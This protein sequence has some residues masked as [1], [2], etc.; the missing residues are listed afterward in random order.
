MTMDDKHK[1][2]WTARRFKE[3]TKQLLPEMFRTALGLTKDHSEAED[4]VH[5]AFVKAY[6]SLKN[7]G[8]NGTGSYRAWIT[9]ILINTYRDR[10]RRESR[11]PIVDQR[12][13]EIDSADTT[14]VIELSASTAPGPA[15]LLDQKRFASAAYAA[16]GELDSE[17]RVIVTLYFF[18]HQSYKQ[19]AEIVEVPIGTVMSRLSRGRRILRQKLA[20]HVELSPP[21]TKQS[22]DVSQSHSRLRQSKGSIKS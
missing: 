6:R 20:Q 16:I 11:S 21:S 13:V 8:F 17:V 2:G 18:D 3:Q 4:L 7:P 12:H 10:C 19:I 22:K 1:G 15:E 9:K 14:N 5:D